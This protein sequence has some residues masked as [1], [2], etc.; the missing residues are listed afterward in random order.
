MK[1][2]F[3]FLA[4]ISLGLLLN[5]VFAQNMQFHPKQPAPG[6][7]VTIKY[8]SEGTD[9]AKIEFETTAYLMTE[10]GPV[11]VEVL[12][13]KK[14]KM[15]E[16]HIATTPAT[17]AVFVTVKNDDER[18]KDDNEA[19]GYKTLMY[20]N[21]Q[22]V[23]GA[24]LAKSNGYGVNYRT[25][26]VKRNFDK[27]LK[28]LQKEFK[29]YPGT[30]ENIQNF[31]RY[32]YY[33]SQTGDEAAKLEVKTKTETLANKKKKSEDDLKLLSDLYRSQ[34]MEEEMK[35]TEG[36]LKVA[37]PNGDWVVQDLRNSF[38]SEKDLAK[39]AEIFETH[40]AKY[41]DTKNAKSTHDNFARTLASTYAKKE[42]WDN[43]NKYMGSITSNLSKAGIYNSLAWGMSGESLEAEATNLEKAEKFSH[44]SLKLVKAELADISNKP[45]YLTEKQW[46]KNVKYSY[47]MYADTYALLKYKMNDYDSA[48]KYQE[49][50]CK[51]SKWGDAVMNERYVVFH[52]KAKGAEATEAVLVDLIMKGHANSKMKEQYKRIFV[53]N[54]T[55]ESAYEKHMASLEAV[56]MDKMRAEM[57]KKMINAP[58]PDFALVNLKGESVNLQDM[59]G[60]VVI[61]DFWATWCGPCKASFP[62]MQ[63]A[64]SKFE[65]NENVEFLFVDTWE[66]GAEK[67]K[68]AADFIESNSYTFNVLMDND[69]KVVSAYG[70]E[71]IPTKFIIGKD[72]NIRY[73]SSGFGGNDDE[74]VNELSVLI[75]ILGGTSS[76]SVTGAP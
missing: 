61:L 16:G 56:A 10:D 28:S 42:D 11:A 50:A 72:G 53:A 5:P 30:K 57:K 73:R 54:N 60:K 70:V 8:N 40:K 44:K 23:K 46:K 18:K 22:P 13:V 36:A 52:E 1:Q 47:G 27:A 67:E 35:A 26:G 19:N 9:L 7:E 38:Y 33:A 12:M 4:I 75:D 3:S 20:Q 69:N 51:T 59:K 25:V 31:N 21:G 65:E 41:S 71:G 15:Y 14:E 49:K 37:Y 66:R 34:R 17:K 2:L 48:L 55:V 32:A 74:L 43:F 64:V 29:H 58:A 24:Y 68:N 63:K 62:A 76:D 39:K 45:D 6:E